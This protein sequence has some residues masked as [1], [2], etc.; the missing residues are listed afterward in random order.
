MSTKTIAK[1]C[2]SCAHWKST[3]PAKGECRRHAPQSILFKVEAGV[4]YEA[5]F[6]V[7]KAE[8]WCGDYTAK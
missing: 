8:D 5:K 7:T 2:A 3:A 6:P 1:S 4:Q